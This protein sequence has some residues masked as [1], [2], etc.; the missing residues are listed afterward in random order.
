MKDK[1]ISY[2]RMADLIVLSIIFAPHGLVSIR[3]FSVIVFAARLIISILYLV[4]HIRKKKKLEIPNAFCILYLGYVIL[5]TAINNMDLGAYLSVSIAIIS[6]VLYS[7]IEFRGDLITKTK[8]IEKLFSFYLVINLVM[9][10]FGFSIGDTVYRNYLLGMR[11]RI[12]D[13]VYPYLCISIMNNYYHSKNVI[14]L[15]FSILLA[16]LN[17][18]IP[19]VATA[20]GAM[21]L[22]VLFM[23]VT[24]NTNIKKTYKILILSVVLLGVSILFFRI[25]NIFSYFIE[26]ILDKSLTFTGRTYIWDGSL[27]YIKSK[28]IF[29]HG[30]NAS[31]IAYH[32][33]TLYQPHNQILDLLANGG[34]IALILFV[35]YLIKSIRYSKSRYFRPLIVMLS[36]VIFASTFERYAHYASFYII[37]AIIYSLKIGEKN[38]AKKDN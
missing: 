10:I 27:E 34:L 31:G 35:I 7:D 22:F 3:P 23:F 13:I 38:E 30:Y 33:G 37:P 1:R 14:K 26:D 20:I 12:P 25:Q 9:L 5:I 24:R 16:I 17:V 11:T 6:F 28:I 8:L 2:R 36:V 19:H 15:S 32:S 18:L 29:G 21:L 4:I